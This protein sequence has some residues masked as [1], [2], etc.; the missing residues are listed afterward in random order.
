MKAPI[1]LI[2]EVSSKGSFCVFVASLAAD[3]QT[4]SERWENATIDQF[5]EA[6]AS[7]TKDMEGYYNN[8]NLAIPKN[9]DWKTFAEMLMAASVYE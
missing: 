8:L 2:S 3:F 5:L 9:V 6:L 4:N 7:W 1:E